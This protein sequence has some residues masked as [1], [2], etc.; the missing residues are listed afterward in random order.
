MSFGAEPENKKAHINQNVQ[1]QDLPKPIAIDFESKIF[2]KTICEDQGKSPIN[3]VAN[4]PKRA[5]FR[6]SAGI[7]IFFPT[8]LEK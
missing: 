6:E 8:W 3:Y 5:G 1:V 7:F 2:Y 4:S